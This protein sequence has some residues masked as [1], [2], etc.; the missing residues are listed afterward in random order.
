MAENSI[1]FAVNENLKKRF[2]GTHGKQSLDLHHDMILGSVSGF[3]ASITSCPFESI[4][5]NAQVQV[6]AQASER[7]PRRP[8]NDIFKRPNLSSLISLYNGF[9]ATCFRTIPYYLFFFPIYTRI[10]DYSSLITQPLL[11]K[12]RDPEKNK[13]SLIIPLPGD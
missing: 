9:T 12:T 2:H 8:F 10:I 6:Q 13:T 5:C 3:A 7:R 1:V 4:K 11:V